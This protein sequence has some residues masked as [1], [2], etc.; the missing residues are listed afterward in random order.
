[1]NAHLKA[2]FR[3][4]ET[5]PV[6]PAGMQR[7]DVERLMR[8]IGKTIGMTDGQIN[9][10]EL[11]IQETRPSDW[12]DPHRQPVCHTSQTNIAYL[13]NLDERSVKRIE[14]AL[15]VKFGSSRETSAETINAGAFGTM[16]AQWRATVSSLANSSRLC[17]TF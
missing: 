13:A 5:Y 4:P 6:L 17:P 10:L 15:E 8:R 11:M 1:M 2:Q 14:R 3:E 9:V 7:S 12:V 16:M